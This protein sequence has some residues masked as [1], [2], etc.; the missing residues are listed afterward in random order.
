MYYINTFADR[1]MYSEYKRELRLHK[2]RNVSQIYFTNGKKDEWERELMNISAK[3]REYFKKSNEEFNRKMKE[4]EAMLNEE[5]LIRDNLK[6]KK[7]AE[8]REKSA[9]TRKNNKMRVPV[10]KS[11]RLNKEQ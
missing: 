4:Q 5:K 10:R 6:A 1:T 3:Y 2:S 8:T 9:E 7:N 11:S